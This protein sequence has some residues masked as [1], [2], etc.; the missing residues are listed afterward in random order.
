MKEVEFTIFFKC[1][2]EC[3][4][5]SRTANLF[6]MERGS[7]NFGAFWCMYTLQGCEI[8]TLGT[9]VN[10]DM[11]WPV[12]SSYFNK[13]SQLLWRDTCSTCFGTKYDNYADNT[14]T[15]KKKITLPKEAWKS[16]PIWNYDE[17]FKCTYSSLSLNM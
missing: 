15:V 6:L 12:I 9:S 11:T 5:Y 4:V 14:L 17:S 7:A 8:E 1:I 16:C 3:T 2:C 10:V 13:G